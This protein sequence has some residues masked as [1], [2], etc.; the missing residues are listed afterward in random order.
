MMEIFT[1]LEQGSSEWFACRAGIPTASKFATV[2]AK[3]EGKSRSKYMRQL[4]G[5]VITGEPAETFSNS[6][7][8][9]GHAMEDEARQTYAFINDVEPVRV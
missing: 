3:G 6:H 1:D 9:R 2:L 7:M 8:E 4:A 5:E